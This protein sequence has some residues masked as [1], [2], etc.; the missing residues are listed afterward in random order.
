MEIVVG[1]GNLRIQDIDKLKSLINSNFGLIN[2]KCVCGQLHLEQAAFLSNKAH[3]GNY[4]LSKDRSTEVLLYL[5][6]QRQ[7]S[8]A[9][10][11]GGIDKNTKSVAWVSFG[12][13][14]SELLNMI[15]SDDS[16]IS[17]D[18]FDYS[19]LNLDNSIVS[20]MSFEEKQKIIMTK[21]AT[22]SVQSR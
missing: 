1:S 21:T 20:D 8:K 18:V 14:P 2:P 22:L 11:I 12:N 4:N 3:N 9:I 15:E 17:K 5:T 16:I 13:P 6:F 7:I 19:I 10:K